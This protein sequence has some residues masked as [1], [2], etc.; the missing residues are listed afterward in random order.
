MFFF[1]FLAATLVL[2]ITTESI[3]QAGVPVI[4]NKLSGI[5]QI[6]QEAGE[7][8][9]ICVIPVPDQERAEDDA[10]D[11]G[12]L[13]LNPLDTPT[14]MQIWT[15]ILS[16]KKSFELFLQYLGYKLNAFVRNHDVGSLL[17]TIECS[18]LQILEG[19][20]EDYRSGHLNAIAQEILVTAEVLEKLG[21]DDVRLKT[22]ISEEEYE[23]GKKIFMEISGKLHLLQYSLA[24]VRLLLC[25]FEG[26]F[27][28][29][30]MQ[31]PNYFVL[32]SCFSSSAIIYWYNTHE[33]PSSLRSQVLKAW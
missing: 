20:W 3:T 32:S 13:H 22:F 21:L 17:I 33:V 8:Q 27:V 26:H 29:C 7:S 15:V 4:L 25:V 5:L 11:P 6:A 9:G 16:F 31:F 14:E 2:N 24:F 30:F 10:S 23:N 28:L 18:S 12:E 19:L 1:C